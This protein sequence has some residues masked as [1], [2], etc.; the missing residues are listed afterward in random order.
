VAGML[1]GSFA[2]LLDRARMGDLG[3]G[4]YA[5][6]AVFA[7]GVFFSSLVFNIFFM[8]LPVEGEPVDF[9]SYFN[10]S[11]KQ[12]LL[13]VGGGVIWCTGVL[14]LMVAGTV[15]EGVQAPVLT[16]YLLAQGAPVLAALWGILVFREFKNGDVSVK[17]LGA[18]MLV[19]FLCGLVMLG[20]APLYLRK[21]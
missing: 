15:P 19:L 2:P 6:T 9:G 11:L 5:L 8:N 7:F 12:H 20:L 21:V 4:P 14:A 1:I 3:L 17:A 16:G 10:G 13:G 18:L